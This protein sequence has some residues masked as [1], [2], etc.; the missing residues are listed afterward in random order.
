VLRGL[1]PAEVLPAIVFNET[2]TKN[3]VLHCLKMEESTIKYLFSLLG[4]VDFV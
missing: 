3:L 2:R 1:P 4:F